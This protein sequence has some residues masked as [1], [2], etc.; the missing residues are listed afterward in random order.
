MKGRHLFFLLALLVPSLG[1]AQL[2]V[3]L[4]LRTPMPPELSAWERDRTIIQLVITNPNPQVSYKSAAVSFTVVDETGRQVVASRDGNPAIPRFDIGT[5]ATLTRYG[6][7]FVSRD[8]ATIDPSIERTA[9]T[10]GRLPEGNY[11]FCV[12][13]LDSGGSEIAS[14]GTTCRSFTIILSSNG[15]PSISIRACRH[16]TVLSSPPCMKANPPGT[17]STARRPSMISG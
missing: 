9:T 7:D 5:S 11:Q 2:T 6:P 3:N 1:T 17:P 12:R 13:I 8:A 16:N 14:T 4:I 10:T 15:R